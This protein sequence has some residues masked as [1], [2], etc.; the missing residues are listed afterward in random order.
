M[1]LEPGQDLR[2]PNCGT[3]ENFQE[4]GTTCRMQPFALGV[5]EDGDIEVLDW[6]EYRDGDDVDDAVFQCR[7]CFTE[8][9]TLGDLQAAMLAAK[10]ARI[11]IEHDADRLELPDVVK[12]AHRP[13]MALSVL[14]LDRKIR[15]FLEANDPKALEQA[16]E[17]LGVA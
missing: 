4:V 8:W 7:S 5:D 13:M 6:Y 11:N 14:I 12:N 15:T 9:A 2:C 10:Q 1:K 17:A 3:S 16:R